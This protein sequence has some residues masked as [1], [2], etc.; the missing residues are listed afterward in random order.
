MTVTGS[1]R[2]RH[3]QCEVASLVLVALCV[4][5]SLRGAARAVDPPSATVAT[6]HLSD[7]AASDRLRFRTQFDGT[8]VDPLTQSL[9]L[10]L[11]EGDGTLL[12]H[13]S[14]PPGSF[15]PTNG[16]MFRFSDT[17]AR[18]V[19][20][21]TRDPGIV[22]KVQFQASRQDLVALPT[23]TLDA[24]FTIGPSDNQYLAVCGTNAARSYSKCTP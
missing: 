5:T 7:R 12:F 3:A 11:R 10:T 6:F 21:R 17:M 19:V 8:G 14:L 16:R 1:L 23:G 13:R 24:R 4:A 20:V 22:F 9:S 18:V 2:R 15:R